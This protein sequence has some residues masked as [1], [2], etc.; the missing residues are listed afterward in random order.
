MGLSKGYKEMDEKKK[1]AVL[2]ALLGCRGADGSL[3][4]GAYTKIARNLAVYLDM[5]Y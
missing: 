5:Y 3:P 1:R 4:H 2:G